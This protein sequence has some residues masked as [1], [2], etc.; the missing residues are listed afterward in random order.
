[1]PSIVPINRPLWGGYYFRRSDRDG[2]GDWPDAPGNCE[3]VIEPSVVARV[4]GPIIISPECI[5]AAV[6]T[7]TRVVAIYVAREGTTVEDLN[8]AVTAARDAMRVAGV[9]VRP[10]VTYTGKTT[11]PDTR[12]DW[13][14]VQCYFNAPADPSV[15]AAYIAREVAKVGG[16]PVALICQSYDR[17]RFYDDVTVWRTDVAAL[18]RL[19]EAWPRAAVAH[20]EA[21]AMLLFSCGRP[22]GAADHPSL[23]AWHRA[24]MATVTTPVITDAE[25]PPSLEAP[26]ITVTTDYPRRFGPDMRLV[27]WM[28]RHN[29]GSGGRVTMEHGSLHVELWNPAGSDKTA[30]RREVT[31]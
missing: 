15:Y 24:M 5:P 25:P 7:W 17:R 22:G 28:D 19:Q 9:A 14:G 20:P 27:E 11:V 12:A 4:P 18:E 23:Q 26:G 6:A 29:S 10:V 2:Y 30:A 16:R 13:T 3:V 31:G 1:M 21:V 8:L